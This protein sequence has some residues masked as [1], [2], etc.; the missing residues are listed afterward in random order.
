VIRT[1]DPQH[2]EFAL[3]PM[4][5]AEFYDRIMQTLRDLGIEV[6]IWTMPVEV[7]N[8]IPS[9]KGPAAQILRCGRSSA[10]LACA[11]AG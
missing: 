8:A 4:P 10:L 6:K 3:T 9:R 7:A 1:S 11:G 2:K 5:V